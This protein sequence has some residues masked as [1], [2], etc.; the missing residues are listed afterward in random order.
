MKY[1][2]KIPHKSAKPN[3]IATEL[4]Y[5]IEDNAKLSAQLTMFP[6]ITNGNY[7]CKPIMSLTPED[8][9]NIHRNL[10]KFYQNFLKWIA[11][12][13]LLGVGLADP[14]D[15]QRILNDAWYL[16]DKNPYT[17][18][19][20]SRGNGKHIRD[21]TQEELVTYHQILIKYSN[22]KSQVPA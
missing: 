21:M 10:W 2:F 18:I 3:N 13:K 17:R 15:I 5:I 4:T 7:G 12:V 20:V 19:P 6:K 1:T 22:R 11:V 14:K 16:L 8:I 9:R